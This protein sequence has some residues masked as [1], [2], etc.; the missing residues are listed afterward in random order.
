[1]ARVTLTEDAREDLHDL[2]GTA[3]LVVLKALKKLETEPMQRGQPLGSRARGDL[4]SFR[5]LV[6]GNRDYRIVY[7]VETDGT[8]V[9]VWVIARRAD[10][11]CYELALARL[12]L[13]GD[14]GVRGLADSLED[15]WKGR[16][17]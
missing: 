15:V 14:A 11:E 2:D 3:R 5:K 16:S 9:V 10:D 17:L 7:R 4:T 6:V 12:R 8:V 1:M 13:H